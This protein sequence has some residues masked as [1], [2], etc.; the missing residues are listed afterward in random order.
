MIMPSERQQPEHMT[1]IYYSPRL[2][3]SP[4]AWGQR[5]IPGPEYL[6][7]LRLLQDVQ[8][9][10]CSLSEQQMPVTS[11]QPPATI[12]SASCYTS[13]YVLRIKRQEKTNRGRL[14][15]LSLCSVNHCFREAHQARQ[16]RITIPRQRNQ[17]KTTPR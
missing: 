17:M 5:T 7:S 15:K 2:P 14:N 13:I 4:F 10:S 8:H 16:K 12:L 11:R 1:V 3:V 6:S 9:G